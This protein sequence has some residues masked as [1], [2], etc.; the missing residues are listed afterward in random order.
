VED[1][2]ANVHAQMGSIIV[3]SWTQTG[4]GTVTAEFRADGGVWQAT[5][6]YELSDGAHTLPLIGAPFAATVTW[7]LL[8]DGLPVAAD[9]E[10]DTAP[11]PTGMP[12]VDTVFAEEGDWD[13]LVPW[14]MTSLAPPDEGRAWTLIINRDGRAVWG[15]ET[16]ELR[17]TFAPQLSV[18][19]SEVLVDHNSWYGAFDGGVDSQ[20]VRYDIEGN[21]L[22]VYDTPGLKHSFTQTGTGAIVWGAADD[23][24]GTAHENLAILEEEGG[25][26]RR[27]LECRD[28]IW[29]YGEI[30]CGSSNVWWDPETDHILYSLYSIQT[31]IE[32]DAAGE[33]VRWFG[34]MDGSWD[35]ADADTT[36]Y[37]QY[38][39]HF[40]ENGNLLLSTRVDSTQEETVIR[41]Y[42]LDEDSETLTQVW[43]YGE[44]EGRY[45]QVMGEARRLPGGH[46]L[47][48]TG[49]TAYLVEVSPDGEKIWDA[50]WGASGGTIGR[51][52]PVE[53]LYDLWHGAP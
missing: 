52:L 31:I 36:F 23:S 19:G 48:N 13:P 11:R 34:H 49:S 24:E 2:Q 10:I 9:A 1:L 25:T 30:L 37:W 51:S 5:P 28:F 33:P 22:G 8:V 46:T 20:V 40:L 39:G 17:T 16:P 41:E 6:S 32:L 45:A 7:R 53:N 43:T 27:L 35:F 18:D 38:G 44:G 21:V 14:I 15:V 3:L 29:K 26:P 50:D 47:W 42:E 12:E 4:T